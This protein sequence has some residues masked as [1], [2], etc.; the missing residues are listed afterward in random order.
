MIL[1]DEAVNIKSNLPL[2]LSI[3]DYFVFMV[4]TRTQDDTHDAIKS[5]L[6]NKEFKIVPYL[7][8]GFGPARTAS[9]Q[10][11]WKHFPH[12]THVWIADPDWKP[13]TSTINI[14]DLDDTSVFRFL[15]YDRNGETTRRCDWLLRHREGLAM[16]Y[17]LHEVLDI[18]YYEW[19][20]IDWVLHEIEQKGSWHT[21][22]GH[23]NSMSAKRY[24]F[25]LEL[26]EKDLLLYGH[27]P[28]THRYLGVTH[29][30]YAERMLAAHGFIT[31]EIEHHMLLAI[32]FLTLRVT[33]T[34]DDEFLEE[35][36]G[37]MYS[38]GALHLR[39]V[40]DRLGIYRF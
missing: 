18:G 24:L 7:F 2:W 11:A 26:L 9:L 35:R 21:T 1:R 3:V 36:W 23:E 14:N 12:A 4:D 38:L 5:I 27:D 28:H 13:D 6:R 17:Y 15:I 16:K 25:D 39:L 8:D 19:K 20:V 33:S 29:D 34:Y 31:P 32:K 40:S 10:N 37:C 30:A 22:V